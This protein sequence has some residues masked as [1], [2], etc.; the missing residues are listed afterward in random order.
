MKKNLPRGFGSS[1]FCA[2]NPKR[3]A[4]TCPGDSGKYGI[5]GCGIFKAGIQ[6][7]KGF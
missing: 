6:N 5:T 1:T 7:W 2:R 4:G 3:T